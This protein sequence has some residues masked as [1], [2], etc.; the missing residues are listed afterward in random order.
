MLLNTLL[1]T[2][3]RSR[4]TAEIKAAYEEF[5]QRLDHTKVAAEALQPG[6]PMPAF[7]LPNAEGALVDTAELLRRGP[8]VVTF[9]RGNWCPYCVATMSAL[10]AVLP[11]LRDA[12]GTLVAL[13]PE[14]GGLALQTKTERSLS[15]EVLVDVDLAVAM[16]FG[17]VFRTPPRYAAL[18][19]NRGID[20]ADR[21]G[22]PGWFLPI[23]ATFLVGTDGI[24]RRSWVDIDFTTRAEP[25][26]GGCRIAGPGGQIPLNQLKPRS[27]Q[28]P[29]G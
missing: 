22:N 20:L 9:F 27:S 15:Y 2:L 13:T 19:A 18:L 24:V 3:R 16:E 25:G 1:A 21:S 5:L 29:P 6:A 8:L 4:E 28:Y 11:A 26:R 14:T 7:L 12:G 10:E 23:P 17:V